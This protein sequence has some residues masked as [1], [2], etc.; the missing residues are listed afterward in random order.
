VFEL[1]RQAQAAGWRTIVTTTTHMGT[2]EG[3]VGPVLVEEGADRTTELDAAMAAHGRAVLLG[4]RVRPDKL[5]GLDPARVAGLRAHADLVLVEAD[6]ARGRSLKVPAEHEPVIPPAATVV[7]VVAALD[8]LGRPLDAETVHRLELVA[9]AA[10][11][12][13]GTTVDAGVVAAALGGAGSY[14]SRIPAGARAVVFLNKADLPGVER[15][16]CKIADRLVPPYALVV[17]GSARAGTAHVP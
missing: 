10:G 4:H 15:A 17:A 16:A 1:A 3:D 6:G 9:S 13:I 11:V 2:P 12:A 5:D 7:I 14:P 8:V